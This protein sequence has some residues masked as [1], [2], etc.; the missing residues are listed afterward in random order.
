MSSE[1]FNL[2]HMVFGAFYNVALYGESVAVKEG[3]QV[4]CPDVL[5]LIP[6][7]RGLSLTLKLG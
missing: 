1:S 2:F 7:R 4:S 3:H 6:L 5:C